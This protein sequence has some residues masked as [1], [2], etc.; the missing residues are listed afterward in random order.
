MSNT[1]PT[2]KVA[3]FRND[4]TGTCSVLTHGRQVSGDLVGEF[5]QGKFHVD[6][7]EDWLSEWERKDPTCYARRMQRHSPLP[8]SFVTIE[9]AVHV[10]RPYL[11]IDLRSQ[12]A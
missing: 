10:R 7:S 3:I 1:L 12:H 2:T 5:R 6:Q 4:S 11:P 8:V 9:A